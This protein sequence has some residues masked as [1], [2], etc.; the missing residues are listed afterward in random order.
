M[1]SRFRVRLDELRA[2]AE[3]HPGLLRGLE[4][5]L[6]AFLQPFIASLQAIGRVLNRLLGCDRPCRITRTVRRWL[7]RKEEARFY[8]YLQQKRLPPRRL[9]QRA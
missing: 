3:V 7:R 6:Q 5:R 1:E 2:D 9:N 8:H 4:Q